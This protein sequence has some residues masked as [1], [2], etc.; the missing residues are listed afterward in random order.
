[1]G[2]CCSPLRYRALYLCFVPATWK[3][4]FTIGSQAFLETNSDLCATGL[5]DEKAE[6]AVSRSSF[7]RIPGLQDVLLQRTSNGKAGM[8]HG[9]TQRSIP[10]PADPGRRQS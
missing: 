8:C 1:V 5:L 4:R 6:L 3:G 7:C 2:S 10:D 9:S